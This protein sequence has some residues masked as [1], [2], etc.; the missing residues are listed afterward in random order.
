[1]NSL[2]VDFGHKVKLLGFAVQ[3]CPPRPPPQSNSTNAVVSALGAL[4]LPTPPPSQP[5]PF[6]PTLLNFSAVLPD[7]ADFLAHAETQNLTSGNVSAPTAAAREVNS[8]D[9]APDGENSLPVGET[10]DEEESPSGGADDTTKTD[11]DVLEAPQPLEIDR[12]LSAGVISDNFFSAPFEASRIRVKLA[13]CGSGLDY[14]GAVVKARVADC[15]KAGIRITGIVSKDGMER[16]N[17]KKVKTGSLQS[18]SRGADFN[19]SAS[20][21]GAVNPADAN[22]SFGNSSF[23][24]RTAPSSTVERKLMSSSVKGN[25][26]KNRKRT[27][28]AGETDGGGGQR[29]PIGGETD[30]GGGQR[31]ESGGHDLNVNFSKPLG[32]PAVVA[33][34]VVKSKHNSPT[35]GGTVQADEDDELR[36]LRD[37][38]EEAYAATSAESSS[39]HATSSSSW[40]GKTIV[41][42]SLLSWWSTS[43]SLLEGGSSSL[44]APRSL[45]ERRSQQ[46][47][48]GRAPAPT[49]PAA[50]PASALYSSSGFRTTDPTNTKEEFIEFDDLQ[51]AVVD[52]VSI[53]G[54][55]DSSEWATE[56]KIIRYMPFSKTHTGNKEADSKQNARDNKKR[57][58]AEQQAKESSHLCCNKVKVCWWK[59]FHDSPVRTSPPHTYPTYPH[60]PSSHLSPPLLPSLPLPPLPP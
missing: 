60:L 15:L 49:D 18:T 14:R 47:T 17:P 45:V 5:S 16:V 23:G 43:R 35:D 12:P 59:R 8:S 55:F 30:G 51:G 46:A 6:F 9:S 24:N 28:S 25:S 41:P 34:R 57:Q 10:S 20:A 26:T 31:T 52:G 50:L 11:E 54:C 56:V 48:S 4:A 19:L 1:M 21:D 27:A 29:M 32:D 22:V 38:S 37:N 53:Q 3:D 40:W 33:D 36:Q 58:I 42:P 39:K 44:T 7:D 13:G 2:L